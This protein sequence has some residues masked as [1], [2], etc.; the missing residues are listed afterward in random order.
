MSY[1]LTYLERLA[2]RFADGS[3]SA[4]PEIVANVSNRN[5][6]QGRQKLSAG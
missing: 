6:K 1:S 2:I 5:L 3:D 4:E